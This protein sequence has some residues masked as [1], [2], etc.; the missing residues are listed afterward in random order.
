ME[1]S[2]WGQLRSG[3]KKMALDQ[4]EARVEIRAFYHENGVHETLAYYHMRPETFA[5]HFPDLRAEEKPEGPYS[6]R[7]LLRALQDEA[8]RDRQR[9][10]RV[11][12]AQEM[13]NEQFAEKLADNFRDNVISPLLKSLMSSRKR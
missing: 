6:D 1:S 7:D 8:E 13:F 11:E 3:K 12:N 2:E 5:R 9:I 4:Q 10:I